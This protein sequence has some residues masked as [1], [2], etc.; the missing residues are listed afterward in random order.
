MCVDTFIVLLIDIFIHIKNYDK[1]WVNYC[2]LFNIFFFVIH[3]Q[4]ESGDL[5]GEPSR[6][7]THHSELDPKS[8][9]VQDLRDELDARNLS[10]KG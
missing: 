7:P 3:L 6:E 4:D 5:G 9:K 10:P 8:M 1:I 2:H